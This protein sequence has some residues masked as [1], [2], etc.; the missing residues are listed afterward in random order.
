MSVD[1]Y[2][3][4]LRALED[5]RT[6]LLSFKQTTMAIKD[7]YAKQLQAMKSAGFVEDITEPPQ[8]RH[9]FFSRKLERLDQLIDD[10]NR[11]IIMQREALQQLAQIA[12]MYS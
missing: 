2:S 7:R 1:N 12:R 8:Q 3:N 10:H 11:K 9:Q 4:H 5:F 6:R